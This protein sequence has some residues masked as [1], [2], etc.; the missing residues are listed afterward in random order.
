MI[1]QLSNL[2]SSELS[3][4]LGWTIIHSLWQVSLIAIIMSIFHSFFKYKS[5]ELRYNISVGSMITVLMMSLVT[6]LIYYTPNVISDAAIV[7][8][9]GNINHI[10]GTTIETGI[11]ENVYQF[12]TGNIDHINLIWTL[13]VLIFSLRLILSYGYVK[14]IKHTS[15]PLE[16]NS[17]LTSIDKISNT[18][19][20]KKMVSLGESSMINVPMIMGYFKP[21]ILFPIGMINLLN[22]EE[23]EAIIVHELSHVKRNDYLMNIALSVL[24]VLYYYHPAMWWISANVKAE[25]ENCCDDAALKHNIDSVTYAK[26]LVKLEEIRKSGIP[27]L[28][29]PFASNKHQLLNRIKRILNM[30]QTKNDIREKSVATVLLLFIAVLFASNTVS[31]SHELIN[32]IEE[33]AHLSAIDTLKLKGEDEIV[34]EIEKGI[35]SSLMVDGSEVEDGEMVSQ[36][37]NLFSENNENTLKV[38]QRFYMKGNPMLKFKDKSFLLHG[39]ES[40]IDVDRNETQILA[41]TLPPKMHIGQEK[42]TIVIEKDGQKIE[43][44]TEN[45]ETVGLKIDGREIPENEF[46]QYQDQIDAATKNFVF[47]DGNF[48]VFEFEENH[49]FKNLDSILSNSFGMIFD[50]EDWRQFGGNVRRFLDD[51]VLRKLKDMEEF[52]SFDD[53]EGFEKLHELEGLE[54]LHELEGLEKLEDLGEMLENLGIQIDSSMRTYEFNFEDFDGF[55][56]FNGFDGFEFFSDDNMHIRDRDQIFGNNTVV[57]KI[58]NALNRDGLLEEFKTNKIEITGKH[59]KINGEKMPKAIYNK[60]KDIYQES[61][62]APLTKKSKMIFEI[63]GKP[64]KRKVRSF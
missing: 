37:K 47:K 25:R 11:L 42:A 20:I 45:G 31:P 28:A 46:D 6:F 32:D 51:D 50:G 8:I 48:N 29:M 12:F 35:F 16:S 2:I 33:N 34:V 24:E 38:D 17:L 56:G 19:Q 22:T 61:T 40:Y 64:S 27:A 1:N 62:G 4:A 44:E 18:M 13:G 58:G 5:P 57:D 41:D 30:E 39:D 26:A 43:V 63:E 53:F 49:N 60:Y 7:P 9:V 15:R 54:N 36:L 10:S 3:Y 21:I 55:D 23:V 14:Y 52:R 59:L